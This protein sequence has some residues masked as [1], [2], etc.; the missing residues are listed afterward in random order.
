VL[1]GLNILQKYVSSGTQQHLRV[2]VRNSTHFESLVLEGA[3]SGLFALYEAPEAVEPLGDFGTGRP[4][5]LFLLISS[6]VKRRPRLMVSGK[7]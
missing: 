1:P 7:G 6:G 5:F 2:S 3:Q 4:F